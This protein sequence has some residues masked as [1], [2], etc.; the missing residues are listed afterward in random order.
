MPFLFQ[1]SVCSFRLIP[2]F[3]FLLK[4]RIKFNLCIC[5]D[6]IG[7][8]KNIRPF[9]VC[10]IQVRGRALK[11]FQNHNKKDIKYCNQTIHALSI[12]EIAVWVRKTFEIFSL[13]ARAYVC[14]HTCEGYKTTVMTF[15]YFT[16]KHYTGNFK[17]ER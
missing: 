5:C 3:S 10:S 1:I 17:M 13:C 11:I 14:V 2:N 6:W 7:K 12:F 8:T 4:F 16:P 15:N 9:V